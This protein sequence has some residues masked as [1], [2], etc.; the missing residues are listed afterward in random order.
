MKT[1]LPNPSHLETVD[2]VALGKAKS[3][4]DFLGDVDG[5]KVVPVLIHGD[6]AFSGQGIVYETLQ[7]ERLNGYSTGGTVHVIFN[8][9]VGFTTNPGEFRSSRLKIISSTILH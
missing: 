2:T 7:M 4:M 1:M 8:N 3:K 9:H 5:H 6:S